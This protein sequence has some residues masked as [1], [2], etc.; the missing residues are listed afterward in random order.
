MKMIYKITLVFLS[1][2]LLLSDSFLDNIPPQDHGNWKLLNEGRIS[3]FHTEHSDVNWGKA[4]S[5]FPIKI[6][7]V[8]STLKDLG[9]Y[10]HIFDRITESEVLD[11][12]ENIVYVRLDMPYFLS[13]RDYTVKYIENYNSDVIVIQFYSVLH[14]NTPDNKGSVTLPR[15]SGEWRLTSIPGK[16]TKVTYIWNGEL[17]GRFPESQLHTAWK[18]QGNEV[19]MWLYK[20]I[21]SNK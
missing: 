13:D 19:L 9:N 1:I 14:P 17:L 16:G 4:T 12:D 8:Y 18:E 11:K 20:Y 15:A 5:T 21:K 10:K 6:D 3:V 2:C 7:R